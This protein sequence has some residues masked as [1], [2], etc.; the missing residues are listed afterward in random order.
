MQR[1]L[2]ALP[3]CRDAL[4]GFPCPAEVLQSF[5]WVIFHVFNEG[6]EFS[7]TEMFV[8]VRKCSLISRLDLPILNVPTCPC[9][10]GVGYWVGAAGCYW[11]AA[12]WGWRSPSALPSLPLGKGWSRGRVGASDA[13][14]MESFSIPFPALGMKAIPAKQ[15]CRWSHPWS[16]RLCQEPWK[17]ET[18]PPMEF[19]KRCCGCRGG[20]PTLLW[21]R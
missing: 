1:I 4:G 11:E 2:A 18:A 3:K 17:C 21:S 14:L 12:E 16:Q 10:Q 13:V 7:F 19:K 20:S 9:R 5:T 8:V 15:R 6:T